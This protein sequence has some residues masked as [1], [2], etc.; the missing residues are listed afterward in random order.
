MCC[1]RVLYF[2]M[3]VSSR[4]YLHPVF[5]ISC[6]QFLRCLNLF[7]CVPHW[8]KLIFPGGNSKSNESCSIK[9]KSAHLFMELIKEIN[10]YKLDISVLFME[11]GA[12]W[13]CGAKFRAPFDS[14]IPLCSV[15]SSTGGPLFGSPLFREA[16]FSRTAIRLIDVIYPV[17]DCF[18]YQGHTFCLDPRW[19]CSINIMDWY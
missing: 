5:R 9:K 19:V 17:M 16:L 12:S 10:Y 7:M 3:Y 18:F 13:H 6:I 2:C 8:K 1:T 14:S 11:N 15:D 4:I